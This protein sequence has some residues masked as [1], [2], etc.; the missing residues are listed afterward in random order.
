MSNKI[1]LAIIAGAES[2]AW[3]A[4]FTAQLDRLE[5]L[6]SGK[7][8]WA[9][10]NTV[11]DDT[12]DDSDEET[13]VEAPATSGWEDDTEEAKPKKAAKAKKLT[14]KDVTEA[15]KAYAQENTVAATKT[16]LKKKFKVNSVT[17]LDEDQWADVI[18]ALQV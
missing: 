8:V 18:A 17:E 6:Q 13:G 7:A 11:E 10:D 14:L 3:L 9:K 16:L 2:K 12:A 4:N 15:C 5:K 1:E